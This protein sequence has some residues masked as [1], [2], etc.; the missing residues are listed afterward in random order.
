MLRKPLITLLLALLLGV[1][2]VAGL[3]RLFVLRYEVGDVYPAYSSLRA[4]PLGT[5]ALAE[6]L[7]A[8]PGVEMRR[9]FKPL[10]QLR[11]G[12]PVTLVYTGVP[13]QAVWTEQ[14]LA[15]FDA[16]VLAGSRALFTFYPVEN[17]PTEKEE[18]RSGERARQK[19]K[20]QLDQK[21]TAT[22]KK[23]SDEEKKD[24]KKKTEGDESGKEDILPGA[25]L[26]DF[27]TVAKRWGFEFAYLPEDKE[28]YQ[29]QAA[30]VEPGGNLEPDITWH[31]ALYFKDLKP[32]WKVL[33]MCGTMPV[34]IERRYGNGSIVLAADSFLVSNEAL[35]TERHPRLLAR[36]FAGPSTVIF[37]EESRGLRDAPGLVHLA[38]KYGLHGVF[39]GLL[40]LAILFVWKNAVR[41]IPAYEPHFAEGDV[42]AG[43]ESSEGFVN[44]LRRSIRPSK[45]FDACIAEWHKTFAHRPRE[46]ARFDEIRAREQ[47]LPSGRDLAARYRAISRSLARKK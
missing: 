43:K 1:V 39:A 6:A 35:S 36:L 9:N 34:V 46:L 5:K 22:G 12:E 27:Q 44:L 40:L 10:P 24:A 21:K 8:L 14:E 4:D 45:I 23:K 30:L 11:A 38:R 33:Y 26:I 29:R 31:S 32:A 42:I 25:K 17:I 16:M 28:A 13:H 41:F 2:L 19:K 37:D 3:S 15:A 18:K 20:E 7:D 47:S